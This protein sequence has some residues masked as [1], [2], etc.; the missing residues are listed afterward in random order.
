VVVLGGLLGGGRR[1]RSGGA[2]HHGRRHGLGHDLDGGRAGRGFRGGRIPGAE[3]PQ[4]DQAGDDPEGVEHPEGAVLDDVA[5]AALAV[6][7]PHQRP[8]LGGNGVTRAGRLLQ[9]G[10]QH[11]GGG[12][13]ILAGVGEVAQ[14]ALGLL[15]EI[16]RSLAERPAVD[17]GPQPEIDGRLLPQQQV[18][19]RR[20][21]LQ[22]PHGGP[23]DFALG[24]ADLAAPVGAIDLE[25]PRAAQA[26]HGAH[27]EEQPE[28]GQRADEAGLVI[29]APAGLVD[30]I[31]QLAG[32]QDV[33][34]EGGQGQEVGPGQ[35]LH[36]CTQRL[37]PQHQDRQGGARAAVAQ[38]TQRAQ[39]R[40]RRVAHHHHG[41]LRL[42]L[43]RPVVGS[44]VVGGEGGLPA[45]ALEAIGQ[46]LEPPGVG[47][48]DESG[49]RAA[50][51]R[52]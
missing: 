52:P 27:Q 5:Q 29:G 42:G 18:V 16:I 7:Q 21:A 26:H 25:D 44:G 39:P 17:V 10:L 14:E 48:Y 24:E 6:E 51:E 49:R 30:G 40:S 34:H 35:G 19:Q 2:G 36:L 11:G 12:T 9:I 43:L 46:R 47:V 28:V 13:Q 50:H 1:S 8:D 20:A 22:R 4:I 15:D 23:D 32:R 37:G 33:A 45:V 3:D 31:E 38:L 41:Q